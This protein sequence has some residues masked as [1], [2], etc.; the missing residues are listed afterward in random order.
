MRK[1]IKELKLAKKRNTPPLNMILKR[2]HE[3]IL[4]WKKHKNH[5]FASAYGIEKNEPLISKYIQN[6]IRR[7]HQHMKLFISLLF[8]LFALYSPSIHAQIKIYKGSYNFSGD[9]ICNLNKNKI[10]KKNSSFSGDV[11]CNIQGNKIYRKNST[12]SGDII[13]Q[14]IDGK[15]YQGN[16]SFSRDM[17]M[18][19]SDG[20]IYKENSSFSGDMIANIQDGRIYKEHSS[21]SGDILFT[22]HGDVTLE[23][24]VAIW[25]TAKYVY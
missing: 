23:E 7:R 19:I 9:V 14:V 20:K 5:I 12:F 10:Y 11:I 13:Y 15:V 1:K 6:K 8:L 25:Y 3:N 16:S 4:S 2:L 24:F 22:I 18:H 21:F 17:L